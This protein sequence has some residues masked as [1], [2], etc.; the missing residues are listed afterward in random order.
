MTSLVDE[1]WAFLQDVA[2]LITF[3]HEKG[4]KLTGGEL[5]R[6][7]EQQDIYVKTGRSATKNSYHLR[8]LAIDFNIFVNGELIKSAQQAQEL[9][10]YWESLHNQN[11]WGGNFIKPVDPPHFERRV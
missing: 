5:W 1:Q 9:G 11:R 4:F 3:A 6:T 8:R 10:N 2:K 7:P